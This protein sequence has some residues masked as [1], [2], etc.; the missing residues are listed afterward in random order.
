MAST[1]VDVGKAPPSPPKSD[2]EKG[3]VGDAI[4]PNPASEQNDDGSSI[5]RASLA[6]GDQTHRRLKSR[7]IQL[8]GMSSVPTTATPELT[9]L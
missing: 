9:R 8:I 5:A 3:V 6:P 2:L 7:H 4:Q 1:G